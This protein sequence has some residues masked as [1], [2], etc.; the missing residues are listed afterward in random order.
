[1]RCTSRKDQ[2]FLDVSCLCWEYTIPKQQIGLT[3]MSHHVHGYLR[4]HGLMDVLSSAM[5]LDI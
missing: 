3:H 5:V 4:V 1:M 2:R